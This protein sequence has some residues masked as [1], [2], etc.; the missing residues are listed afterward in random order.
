MKIGLSSSKLRV[1]L[2]A[3]F[4]FV[5][6]ALGSAEGYENTLRNFRK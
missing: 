6:I 3:F 5:S 2:N 1:L 4:C